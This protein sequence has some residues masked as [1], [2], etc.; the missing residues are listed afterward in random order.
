MQPDYEIE[1]WYGSFDYDKASLPSNVRLS[2]GPHYRRDSF[3]E[4]FR[5]WVAFY[6]WLRKKIR[7]EDTA[8]TWF[9]FVSN[10]PLFVFLPGIAKL[11]FSCLIYDL[12]PDVLEGISKHG[13]LR[14][15]SSRWQARNKKV[16]PKAAHIYTIGEGLKHAIEN[17]SNHNVTLV[18]VWN[19]E[20]TETITS[21]RD[22]KTEWGLNNRKIILYSGNIGLTHPLE[23]LIELANDLK[24]NS[25]WQIVI[26]GSGNKKAQLQQTAAGLSNVMFKD[27]VPFADL[28]Q[29]L[30]IATW[31]YVTLDTGATNGSVPSKTFNLLAAGIPI[32]ALVNESSEIARLLDKYNA[33]IYFT[34]TS[35]HPTAKKL[36]ALSDDEH[37]ELSR[38]AIICSKDFT[39]VLAERFA[40]HWPS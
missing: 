29:L 22:F 23:Y 25:E 39:P 40:E 7:K 19:K 14:R 36:I 2:E 18:P 37:K 20:S 21:D 4:R 6:L 32:L 10:P 34:E 27:P 11:R 35:I 28:R 13:F 15:L 30:S 38:N 12:Y 33:G 3:K 17:Y 26:V 16:F 5:S 8:N 31:G 9:F 1:A 24:T